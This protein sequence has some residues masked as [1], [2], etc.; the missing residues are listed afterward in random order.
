MSQQRSGW[1]TILPSGRWFLH[2]PKYASYLLSRKRVVASL[3]PFSNKKQL[4]NGLPPIQPGRIRTKVHWRLVNGHLSIGPL[5]GILTVGDGSTF[6]GNKGNFKDIIL[7]GKKLGALVYVFTPAGIDWKKKRVLGYL[8]DEKLNNWIETVLPFPHVVYNRIPTRRWEKQNDVSKTLSQIAE[9][10]NVTLFN[11]QFFN[12]QSL[13][14]MLS[15]NTEVSGFLPD[16][17]K[18]DSLIR[19]KLFCANHPSVYLKPVLGR[20]GKGIMRLDY[21]NNLWRLKRVYEQKSITRHFTSLDQ[22]W[23]H[24]KQHTKN[25]QYIIQ[26]GIRLARY[27]GRPFD[28]RVLVQKNGKGEWGL[29]GIGIRRA[30]ANSITT[31]VP[32]GGSI[33]SAPKVLHALFQEEAQNIQRKITEAALTIARSLNE[34][35]DSL[36]EMSMD[37]GLTPDGSLWFFE[38]NAK[39]EK[40]DEPSIRRSS[41]NNLIHYAQYVSQLNGK[42]EVGIG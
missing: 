18:M 31:H 36:A 22:V 1:L 11:R 14:V 12:K 23:R 39:P 9:L 5:I 21:K 8:F 38:A 33:Q 35:I 10:Q 2:T 27:K 41:L 6:I 3:G 42:R 20:A 28:V 4:Y 34:Q 32:R 15:K 16:T 25:K 7:S 26:Q 24:M 37:L 13:F 17:K 30:G 40:F 19:L 29:T